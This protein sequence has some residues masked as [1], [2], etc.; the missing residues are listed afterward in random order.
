[1]VRAP[2]GFGQAFQAPAAVHVFA[3]PGPP[4]APSSS[5][6]LV[7]RREQGCTSASW[8]RAWSS[9]RWS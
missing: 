6:A 9:W 3:T 1:M 4:N 8:W 7:T 5:C 2:V